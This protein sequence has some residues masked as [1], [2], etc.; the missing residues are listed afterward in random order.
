MELNK[1]K[2]YSKDELRLELKKS[3]AWKYSEE[4]LKF[5]FHNKNINFN[6]LKNFLIEYNSEINK[7]VIKKFNINKIPN[8]NKD[9]LDILKSYMFLFKKKGDYFQNKLE[10]IVDEVILDTLLYN[11]AFRTFE[12]GKI[13][14]NF[15]QNLLRESKIYKLLR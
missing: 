8:T 4:L 15:D 2:T 13:K 7:K 10:V 6:L 5:K 1:I 3:N 12:N 9:C 11:R 14:I